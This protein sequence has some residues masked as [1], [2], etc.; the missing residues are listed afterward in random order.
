MTNV[1]DAM[2]RRRERLEALLAHLE[3][4]TLAVERDLR[5][6]DGP[7]ASDSEEQAVM[8]QNDDVLGALDREGHEQIGRIREALARM[9]AGTYGRCVDCGAEIAEARLEALPYA[10]TCIACAQ[11]RERAGSD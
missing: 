3:R 2:R 10:L 8:L 9:E 1:S 11:R 7:L 4:R 6:A 5:R